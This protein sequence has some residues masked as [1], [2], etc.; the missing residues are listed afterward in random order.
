MGKESLH[1]TDMLESS[2]DFETAYETYANDVY[3]FM[4]WRTQNNELSQDLTSHVFEKAWRARTSFQGGSVKAWLYRIARNTLVDHWRKKQELIVED[5]DT[6]QENI[7]N[8][9]TAEA[10]DKEAELQKLRQAV[11][12]LPSEMRAVV[13]LRFISNLSSREVAKQLHMSEGNVRV[14]Q[15]RALKKLRE[16]LK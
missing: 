1:N 12:G 8:D 15:Y 5:T 7:V 6:L 11:A 2:E 13:K 16:R 14:I 10:L 9:D 4:L 3:R